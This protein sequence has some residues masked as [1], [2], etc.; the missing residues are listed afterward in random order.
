MLVSSLE[1]RYIRCSKS[2]GKV[3][4]FL[5][6]GNI[7]SQN[8]QSLTVFQPNGRVNCNVVSMLSLHKKQTSLF[9]R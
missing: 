5:L 4:S 2:F 8:F 6:A 1:V 9:C 3:S 7:F